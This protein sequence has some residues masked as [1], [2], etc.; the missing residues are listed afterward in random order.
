MVEIHGLVDLQK[1]GNI[2]IFIHIDSIRDY[3]IYSWT[4]VLSILIVLKG[5]I[6]HY[7]GKTIVNLPLNISKF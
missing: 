5:M 3:F 7:A 2:Y 1:L 6:N 4:C